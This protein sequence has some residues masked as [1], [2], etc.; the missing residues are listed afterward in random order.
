MK[1]LNQWLV[2]GG[3]LVSSLSLPLFAQQQQWNSNV[4]GDNTTQTNS[5]NVRI[6][7]LNTKRCLD[8]SKL[9]KQ[10]QSNFEKMKQQMESILQDRGREIE[11]IEGKLNDDDYMDSISEDAASELRRNRRKLRQESLQ[12][13]EQYLQTLQQANVK[14]LQRITGVVSKASQQV[15]QEL[16][17]NNQPVVILTDEACTYFTAQL[18]VTDRIIAKMNTI[19]D[20]EPKEPVNKPSANLR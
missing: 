12:L 6:C 11:E 15:A 17:F 4:T 13:Q 20:A 18:D 19:Y 16:A 10:E 1:K 7:V 8:E 9:G 3:C 5:S 14:I 2:I